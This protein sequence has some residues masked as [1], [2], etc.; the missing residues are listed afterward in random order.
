MNSTIYRPISEIVWQQPQETL[1]T[2]IHE[3]STTETLKNT[4]LP[5][6]RQR[7]DVESKT[8]PMKETPPQVSGSSTERFVG[9]R[10]GSTPVQTLND[11]KKRESE[12][13]RHERKMTAED[14]GDD[15]VSPPTQLIFPL[16]ND[17]KKWRATSEGW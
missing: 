7:N 2:N 4:H 1:S 8:S 16:N 17:F 13:Q 14:N 6:I 15:I 12:I 10:T 9:N 5:E 11:S 3:Y